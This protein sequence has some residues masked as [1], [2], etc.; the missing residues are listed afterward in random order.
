MGIVVSTTST[1]R[2][3]VV[4]T[5]VFSTGVTPAPDLVVVVVDGSFVVVVSA[6]N[7]M[8]GI[9]MLVP[10]KFEAA[11]DE[12]SVTFKLTVDNLEKKSVGIPE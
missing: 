10:T 9:E 5:A 11:G 2:V 4:T 7:A 3:V 12:L 8:T 1:G 6:P